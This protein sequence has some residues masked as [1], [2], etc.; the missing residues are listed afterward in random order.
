MN[1]EKFIINKIKEKGHITTKDVVE[2]TGFTRQ[3]AHK[4]IKK[5][6]KK[7]KIEKIG[8]RKGVKYVLREKAPYSVKPSIKKRIELKDAAEDEI[9]YDLN[10]QYKFNKIV[11]ENVFDILRYTFTE[12]LNNAIEHSRS[13]YA[14][15]SMKVSHYDISF[16]IDDW[17]IGIYENIRKKFNLKNER[18]A[19]R[20]LIKGK[21]TTDKE[22]HTGEGLF[23]T[24]K[25]AD[26]VS[27]KSHRLEIIFNNLENEVYVNKI[28]FNKG[29]KVEFTIKKY[30]KKKL[31]ELFEKFSGEEFNYNFSRTSVNVKLFSEDNHTFISRSEARRLLYNLDKYE[32]IILDFSGIKKVGQGFMDEIFRVFKNQNPEISIKP[33]NTCEAVKAMIEHVSD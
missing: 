6:I 7:G 5:L 20:E 17:G 13:E 21:T 29:T 33:K 14:N 31:E 11:D 10:L 28:Q 8:E 32:E 24:S 18:D 27:I 26:K 3:G 16:C 30:S 15:I 1:I 12:I 23:F 9:F 19:L 25:I 2:K 22:R 4:H